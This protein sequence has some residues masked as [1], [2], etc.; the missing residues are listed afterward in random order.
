MTYDVACEAL[1]RHFLEDDDRVKRQAGAHGEYTP[2]ELALLAQ[3][4]QD[5]IENYL[6]T[7]G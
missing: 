2:E 4:I 5:A 3:L 7:R 6:G 1:A